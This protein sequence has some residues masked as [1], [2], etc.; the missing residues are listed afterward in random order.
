M[1]ITSLFFF[2]VPLFFPLHLSPTTSA[3]SFAAPYSS[4]CHDYESSA[5]WLFK[6][7]FTIDTSA[8][9]HPEASPK[10][11]S[12]HLQEGGGGDCCSWDGV[13]C[14]NITG[15]VIGLDLRSSGLSGYIDSHNSLFQLIHLQYLNLADNDFLESPIPS[16]LG[17]LSKLTHLNLSFSGFSGQIPSNISD[18]IH[19]LSLDLSENDNLILKNSDFN[20]LVKNLVSLEVLHLDYVDI[21]SE[22]PHIF[23]NSPSLTSLSLVSCRLR[24]EFPTGIL[25]L[26]TLEVLYLDD[27]ENLRA[28]TFFRKS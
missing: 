15:H 5:L 6:E 16:G 20:T 17:H 18:L 22:V 10:V 12:W 1:E 13:E 24:G 4:H 14:D 2:L 3:A 19:L 27:N 26:P 21:S 11:E 7:S 28:A 8:S 9:S 23:A 25:Q